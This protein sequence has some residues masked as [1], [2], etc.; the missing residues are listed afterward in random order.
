[1]SF[2]LWTNLWFADEGASHGASYSPYVN[3]RLSSRLTLN[4]GP[5]YSRDHNDSQWLD[6]FTDSATSAVHYS[7]A[8]LEQRTVSL[9]ARVSYTMSPVLT[10][11][12][13]GQPFVSTGEYSNVREVSNATASRY[14]DRF[15]PFTAPDGTDMSFK[16]TQLRTNSVVRWE[17]RPGSTL[18]VVWAHG[19]DGSGLEGTNQSWSQDYRDL[20]SLHP[21]NTFL[22]KLAYWLNR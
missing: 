10:F 20:F 13:Y 22:V 17:F 21:E 8:H 2:G 6:N 18:F 15:R 11:E 9:S 1:V 14:A 4:V 7:F 5:N 19:R 12:F 3:F 16:Y